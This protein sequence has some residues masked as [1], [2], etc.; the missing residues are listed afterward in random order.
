[1]EVLSISIF[2]LS[3]SMLEHSLISSG[4]LEV[5]RHDEWWVR[6]IWFIIKDLNIISASLLQ[7]DLR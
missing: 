4:G 6:M 1:M 5:T 2:F 3:R 7:Y